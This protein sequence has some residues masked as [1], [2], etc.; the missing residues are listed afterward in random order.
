MTGR[1][2][3]P[4]LVGENC[5]RHEVVLRTDLA[6]DDGP[7]TGDRVQLQQVLLNLI[8]NGVEAMRG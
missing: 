7:V 6:V 1:V 8:M 2:P 4:G 5:S 3:V